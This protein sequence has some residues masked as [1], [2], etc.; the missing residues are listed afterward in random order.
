MNFINR[1]EELELLENVFEKDDFS[2]ISISGRRRIGKTEL[3]KQFLNGREGVYLYVP[4]GDSLQLRLRYAEKLS[5]EFGVSFVGRPSWRELFEKLFE[6]SKEEKFIVV[7]DEFQRFLDVD[8]VAPSIIQEMIDEYKDES[9]MTLTVIGSSI[10]MMKSMFES[11]AP[12]YGRR[13]GQ[14]W[15]DPLSFQYATEFLHGNSREMLKYYSVFG[16]TPK[17]LEFVEKN[18]SLGENIEDSIL[19][20]SSILYDEPETLLSTELDSPDEYLEILKLISQG[21]QTPKEITDNLEIEKTS[22]NYYAKNLIEKLGLIEKEAPATENP[23]KSRNNRYRIKDNFFKFYFRFVYPQ[24]DQLELGNIEG[25]KE[26]IM[27]E[28]DGYTGRVFEN[29][30]LDWIRENNGERGLG[31]YE[32]IGRWWDRQGNEVDICGTGKNGVLLGEIKYGKISERKARNLLK[33]IDS[34]D[35]FED[36]RQKVIVGGQIGSDAKKFLDKRDVVYFE[37]KDMKGGRA[38]QDA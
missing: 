10:G 7:F 11:S 1:E 4:I 26:K 29:V 18:K 8:E 38:R 13:T 14:I 33:K 6:R 9:K 27:T 31:T 2:F 20:S 5:E 34:L 15:L 35:Y 3:V 12:L 21:K 25:V 30:V 37:L 36:I 22:F 32:R 19:S 24:R 28:I 23:G 16:G 17:Y